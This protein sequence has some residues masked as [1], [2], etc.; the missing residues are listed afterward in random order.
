MARPGPRCE[1]HEVSHFP[2][3]GRRRRR[4]SGDDERNEWRQQHERGK[5]IRR[6]KGTPRDIPEDGQVM[7][8]AEFETQMI[9]CCGTRVALRIQNNTQYS[10]SM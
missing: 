7:G 5:Q 9:L 3:L 8:A 2:R 4:V 6:F 1:C 10:E